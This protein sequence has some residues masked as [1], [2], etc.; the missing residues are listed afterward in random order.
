VSARKVGLLLLIVLFGATVETAWQV[1]GNVSFGPEGCRVM[2]GR[3]YGPSWSFEQSAERAAAGA[4]PRLEIRNAFGGVRVKAG[5]AGVVRV[6]LRKVVFQ[7]TEEKAKAFAERIE[8]RLEGEGQPLR[9]STN[10]EELD[11]TGQQVGFETHLEI[12]VPADALV[13]VR[14][15]HGRVDVAGVAGAD[16]ESSFDDVAAE[17]I[18]GDLRLDCRHG[19]VAV[20]GIGGALQLRAR[21]GGVEVSDV[22]GNAKL[23][24]QH[25]DLIARRTGSL[26]I[27]Q[28]HGG[29]TAEGVAGD[30]ETRASHSEVLVSD[31]RGTADVET[32]FGAVHFARIGGM[33]RAKVDHGQ[34]TAEDIQGGLDAESSHDGVE[35]AR[36]G[37]PL[38]ATVHNGSVDAKG[39]AQGVRVNSSGGDVTLDGVAGAIEVVLERGSAS[40]A[41][42]VVIT[43]PVS[44]SVANG[45]ARLDVPAGSRLDLDTR[46]RRGE[47]RA[48]IEDLEQKTVEKGHGPGESLRARLAGG[49]VSVKLH[50]DGDV[51]LASS[52]A[53][54]IADQPIAAPRLDAALPAEA[55][56]A[57]SESSASAPQTRQGNR[58]AAPPSAPGAQEA[59]A[60]PA[61]PKQP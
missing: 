12:E 25:G 28:E 24:V 26:Q 35:V 49:G 34:V 19:D 52:A 41:P 55:P 50:A 40:I 47:V 45:D 3:F 44:V 30:I 33:A 7:E 27:T 4:A 14:N 9:V 48:E 60:A 11:R 36:L 32:S 22:K 46:S 5:A 8:L 31:V 43:G 18:A 39:L 42:R 2:S 59:P 15:D 21:H 20:S 57:R 1:R 51:T 17:R 6:K 53:S 13:T 61:A 10:R 37:G 58:A 23:E 38:V 54:A 56:A 29:V 16:I